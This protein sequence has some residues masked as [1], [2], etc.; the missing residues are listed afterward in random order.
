[1][2]V[3][4]V[5]VDTNLLM[6]VVVGSVAR[7]RIE[8]HRRLK[9]F[10]GGDYDR[11][12]ALLGNVRRIW[13]TPNVLTETS[14]LLGL[15]GSDQSRPYAVALRNLIGNSVEVYVPSDLAAGRGEY[16]YLGLTDAGLLE[17]AGPSRP[18]LTVDQRLFSAA[19][20]IDPSIA[21]NVR[22]LFDHRQ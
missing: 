10:R 16:Q 22:S 19:T 2:A 8:T 18:L 5:T 1:M 13:V 4:E 11:L 17:A 7:E 15:D 3:R 21:V 9:S 12:L 6:L 20:A 14:N